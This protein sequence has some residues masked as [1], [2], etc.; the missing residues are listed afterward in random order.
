MENSQFSQWFYAFQQQAKVL[1]ERRLIVLSG[2]DNWAISLLH[3]IESSNHYT[4]SPTNKEWLVYGGN[5]LLE[6][7]VAPK[8]FRQRL[9]TES[10]YLVFTSEQLNADAIA[11]LSG[12]L[13]GGG[14]LFL[15]IND[16]PLTQQSYFYKRFFSLLTDYSQHVVLEQKSLNF[17]LVKKIN[18]IIVRHEINTLD[19]S[20]SQ[21]F[22]YGCITQEQVNAVDSIINVVKGKSKR[23]LVLTADRGRGKSSALAIACAQLLKV[24]QSDNKLH[25]VIT[26][27]DFSSV[28]VFFKQLAASFLEGELQGYQFIA[29]SNIVEFIPIDQLLKLKP[30]ASLLLVDE[31]ATIPVY[32][33]E[34]LL[35]HYSRLVFAST[36]HGYEGAGRGFSLKFKG[37]LQASFPKYCNLHINEP[38]RWRVG[39]P[40]EQLVFDSCLLNAEL[41]KLYKNTYNLSG[42]KKHNHFELKYFSSED[43]LADESL[44]KQVFAVLVT[45][46]YQT[47]PSDVQM[48]LDNEQVQL[49]CYMSIDGQREQVVAVA[50]LINEGKFN[51]QGVTEVELN[52]I[53][54][55]KRRLKNHFTPQSLLTH[56][57]IEQAF[58]YHYIR[59]MRIAVHPKL[60]QQGIG[61]L[62]LNEISVFAE[63]QG[64]DYLASSFGASKALLSFWFASEFKLVRIGFSKD[65]ASGERSALVLRALSKNVVDELKTINLEFYRSFDYLLVEEYKYLAIDLTLLILKHCPK[66]LLV[67][68]STL[69]KANVEA[70]AR[71]YRQYST[72]VFSIHQWLKQQVCYQNISEHVLSIL[73]A[74]V[75]QKF[76]INEVCDNYRFT[77]KKT[78]EQF[79]RANI[80]AAL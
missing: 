72:C 74:R 55:S 23:P 4:Q 12:T 38:I 45:A 44:L 9:G 66:S 29:F 79:L 2:E 61:T 60:Q 76:S 32:L 20:N 6:A 51:N 59:V 56:C 7:N 19:E 36:I 16:M 24:A 73:I 40:L 26:S 47:K 39:D 15:L 57:G 10:N 13:V 50:L 37:I 42:V 78:L 77:G 68:L 43:L 27:A 11:A 75:M 48:L 28:Q 46:H 17:P 80:K 67:E 64:A 31:A 71:G 21:G 22:T 25:I 30:K 70:F 8:N 63:R 35:S 14:I 62:F 52:A 3:S 41:P 34:Q 1:N 53:K 49:V 54:Q 18:D 33:L 5:A 58:D 65:K 69:D